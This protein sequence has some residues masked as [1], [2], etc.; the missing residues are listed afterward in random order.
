MGLSGNIWKGPNKLF[1]ILSAS[2]DCYITSK[3]IA[4]IR[5]TDSNTGNAATCDIFAL[6]DETFISSSVSGVLELSRMLIQFD[7]SQLSA[8]TSSKLN[9]SDSSFKCFLNL[10][11]VYGGQTT[12]SNF[13]LRLIPLSK[14][15]DEGRGFDVVAY[16]D[17]DS[18]NF[19]T[20]S[21]LNGSA[22]L[23][24]VSGAGA[25]GTLGSP[26]IDIIVSGNIGFGLQD[27]TVSQFFA[28]GD[29]NF[30]ADITHLVSASIAGIL[31]N[32][33][34]RI[35]FSDQEEYDATTRFVKR[36]GTRHANNKSLHPKLI[37]KYNDSI[38]DS[39]GNPEF[40]VNQNLFIYN[41]LNGQYSNFTSGSSNIT[42]SNSLKLRLIASKS[43]TFTTT[44]YS[45]SHSASIS[46][47]TRSL[48]VISQSFSASQAIIGNQAQTGIYSAS[49]L[50]ST[51]TN[52]SLIS[53]LSGST[54]QMFKAEW[55]SND[56]SVVFAK[57][58][59]TFKKPMGMFSNLLE[60]NY[61][62]NVTNLRQTYTKNDVARLRVF[63]Q[64]YNTE[65][66]AFRYALNTS[67]VILYNMKWRLIKA[68][69]KDVVIPFDS[70][71][72]L[73][74]TDK[75]GMYFDLFM[76]DFDNN[77]VYEIEFLI[78]EAGKDQYITNTGY[79]FK[80]IN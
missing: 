73:C 31:P 1:R 17:I 22:S 67:S 49:I 41:I 9:I 44:S 65:T 15:F 59:F 71:A 8:L 28:R 12:P 25:S 56:G 35:G 11:D 64:D 34:F 21:I 77:E 30:Y 51:I 32:N 47:I 55:T 4:G 63:V 53:F 39:N 48:Y 75:D 29:E 66:R 69:S 18:A 19:I 38:I 13:T 80:V 79:R 72:T 46:H 57:D 7:Y 14:S 6:K 16:R 60:S 40:N 68:F 74:S 24:N 23:W 26:N 50:L 43:I 61:V 78:T 20:A 2:K 3:F 76:Q 52:Q 45:I 27:M 33:G 42:G 36:F 58:W 10:K 37:V 54:E 70:S 5:S 62:I